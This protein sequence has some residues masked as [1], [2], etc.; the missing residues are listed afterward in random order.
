M[1]ERVDELHGAGGEDHVLVVGDGVADGAVQAPDLALELD[2]LEHAVGGGVAHAVPPG[3]HHGAG[4]RVAP[5]VRLQEQRVPAA[6]ANR[7]RT[8]IRHGGLDLK[9]TESDSS[10]SPTLLLAPCEPIQTVPGMDWL[11]WIII[12]LLLLRTSV[13]IYS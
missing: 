1:H 2:G 10:P 3:D 4:G 7:S 6:A 9:L 11:I 13:W 5:P 12:V 8:I